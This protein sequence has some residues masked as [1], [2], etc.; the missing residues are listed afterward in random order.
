MFGAKVKCIRCDDGRNK[1][2]NKTTPIRCVDQ[3]DK[4]MYSPEQ[5]QSC[6]GTTGVNEYEGSSTSKLRTGEVTTGT[7][8]LMGKKREGPKR[9][10]RSAPPGSKTHKSAPPSLPKSKFVGKKKAKEAATAAAW[11]LIGGSEKGG[12]KKKKGFSY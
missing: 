4:V 8:C 3:L 10:G 1:A 2:E 5:H 9:S 6:S 7:T 12:K 11:A